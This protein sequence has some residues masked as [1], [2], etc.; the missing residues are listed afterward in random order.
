M[1]ALALL[2]VSAAI[3]G[4]F[5]TAVRPWYLRWGA[6]DDE[7]RRPLPGDE[8]IA[9]AVAQQ[10]RAITIDAPVAHIWPWMA[11]LGQDRGGFYSFDL[12]E[13][14]VGC[15]M[16]TEDRLRPEKQSWRVGDKLWMY[17]KR[18]AG[19]IG[20]ATLHVY[21][22]GRALGFG[23]HVAGTAPTGPEDGSWSFVLEP[24]DAWTT[25]LL[26]RERGAAGRS[27]LGVAFD[28]SIFEPI[29]FM[30]ERRMM[31]G[32]KQLGEGSSR[33]RVLNHVHVAFFVVA[34]A[35]VLVGAVQVLRRER[36]WRPLGGFIAAAVVFQVLTLVQPPIG[37][38][39]VLLGLVAGILWWPQRVG[40]S[41]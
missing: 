41:S 11:Q 3:V 20:F 21:L 15:E 36:W 4:A 13:N 35:F 14:V 37:V 19:G 25:R 30:M 33:G 31:I 38:G 22:G 7:M 34:F 18:K 12:L 1:R 27:L 5:F 2:A 32:L 39:A 28:R 9:S 24:L 17:P 26:V 40:A 10:T 29:H 16:P 6:T 23:T 8:I